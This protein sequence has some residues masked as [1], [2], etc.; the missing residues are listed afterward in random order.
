LGVGELLSW[1]PKCG[2]LGNYLIVHYFFQTEDQE[3]DAGV[4]VGRGLWRNVG[5]RVGLG[6]SCVAVA[7]YAIYNAS[8]S[9]T[10][11]PLGESHSSSSNINHDPE[12]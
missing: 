5:Y 12:V 2:H 6:L 11:F 4:G 1:V 10:T 9:P 3:D 7:A 8:A